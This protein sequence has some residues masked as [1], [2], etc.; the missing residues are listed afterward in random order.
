MKSIRPF[1][2]SGVSSLVLAWTFP[3]SSLSVSFC[4]LRWDIQY[5][6]QKGPGALRFLRI[7]EEASCLQEEGSK[8]RS[9]Q[10][11]GDLICTPIARALTVRTPAERTMLPANRV[12]SRGNP[13]HAAKK[14]F[15]H[16][17]SRCFN[18]CFVPCHFTTPCFPD[19]L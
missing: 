6:A 2:D 16:V 8:C 15:L 3:C 14:V 18:T 12:W 10:I 7:G 9:F 19:F 13:V 4:F 11:S 17:C 5:R 1:L